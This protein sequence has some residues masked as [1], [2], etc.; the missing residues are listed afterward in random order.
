ML[1]MQG[2]AAEES[3]VKNSIGPYYIIICQLANFVRVIPGRP[4][5]CTYTDLLAINKLH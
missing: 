1:N 3:Y 5:L 2:K 4:V